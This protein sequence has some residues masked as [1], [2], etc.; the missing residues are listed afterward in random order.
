MFK[1]LQFFIFLIFVFEKNVAQTVV[2]AIKIDLLFAN[3]QNEVKIAVENTP[4]SA[5]TFSINNG[6]IS[7]IENNRFNVLPDKTGKA[8][9]SIFK[10]GNKV[11][12]HFFRVKP[13]PEP[14]IRA[15]FQRMYSKNCRCGDCLPDKLNEIN[16]IF[17]DS[18]YQIPFEV[19]DFEYVFIDKNNDI[20][21]G[22]NKGAKF[23]ETLL[24]IIEK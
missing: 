4:I 16:V 3:I 7:L 9:I 22:V 19:F 18:P 15:D 17:E 23:N 12:E 10:T 13:L 20:Q 11:A 8:T 6:T 24:K 5:L 1:T 21:K 14:K 2:S